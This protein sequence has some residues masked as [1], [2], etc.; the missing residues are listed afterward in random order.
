MGCLNFFERRVLG[1]VR[2]G[3]IRGGEAGFGGLRFHP[4]QVK[5]SEQRLDGLPKEP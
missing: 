3:E 1:V 5:R 2:Q 4:K